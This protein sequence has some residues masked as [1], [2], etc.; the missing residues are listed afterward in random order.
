MNPTHA[1]DTTRADAERA[2]D[3]RLD[4]WLATSTPPT[5]PLALRAAILA[6]TQPA[7]PRLR[8]VLA[9]LWHDLGGARMAAPAFALALAAGVGLGSG[10]MPET[11]STEIQESDLLSLAL[12]DDD[13]LAFDP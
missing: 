13:Y 6:A 10:L 2:A 11:L 3:A 12:I 5:A 9:A 7:R 8:D 4:A 1:P